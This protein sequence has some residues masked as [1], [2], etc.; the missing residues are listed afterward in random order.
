MSKVK[1]IYNGDFMTSATCG[2]SPIVLKTDNSSKAN[3]AGATYTPVDMFVTSIGACMLSMMS[4]VGMRR[5]LDISGAQ[6]EI[7]YASDESTHRV[8]SITVKFIFP[9]K[10]LSDSDKKVLLA[11]A[12]ACPV[13][14][15]INPDIRKELVIE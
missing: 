14:A 9:G 7:D 13:G 12:K 15:S 5:N 2:E 11:A 3:A 4:V 1:V 6:T 8:T 10:S